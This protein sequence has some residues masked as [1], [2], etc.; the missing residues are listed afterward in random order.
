MLKLQRQ[1]QR[2]Q[3][4]DHNNPLPIAWMASDLVENE[5]FHFQKYFESTHLKRHSFPPLD[6]Y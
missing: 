4:D 1:N 5:F 2:F 6:V 3:F